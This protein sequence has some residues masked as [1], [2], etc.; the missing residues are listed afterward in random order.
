MK[1]ITI[2]I[3]S[4]ISLN[5]FSNEGRYYKDMEKKIDKM[6]F[7]EAKKMKLEKIEKKTS[8]MEKERVCINAATD[9]TAIKQCMKD[10]RNEKEDMDE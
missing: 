1:M 8:M 7:E 3:L 6:S 2:A 5:S 4:L 9:K 10:M